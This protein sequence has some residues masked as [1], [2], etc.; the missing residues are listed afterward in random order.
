MRFCHPTQKPQTSIADMPS[1]LGGIVGTASQ[2][3]GSWD[4]PACLVGRPF[5]QQRRSA[6]PH[7][8]WVRLCV[9]QSSTSAE[10]D[11]V[12]VLGASAQP[13]VPSRWWF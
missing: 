8:P 11:V 2:L 7:L 13:N 1:H 5:C 4:A 10:Y 3:S 12:P 6:A 9:E